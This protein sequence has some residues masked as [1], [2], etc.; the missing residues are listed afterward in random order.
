MHK[1]VQMNVLVLKM[2]QAEE[3]CKRFRHRRQMRKNG[4][5]LRSQDLNN[6]FVNQ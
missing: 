6:E 3:G 4:R 1:S 2:L 5:F